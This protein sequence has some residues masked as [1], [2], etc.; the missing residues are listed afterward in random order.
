MKVCTKCCIQKEIEEF[1]KV[2]GKPRSRC[3]LCMREETKNYYTTHRAARRAKNAEWFAKNKQAVIYRRRLKKYNISVE[4][5]EQ[6]WIECGGKCLICKTPFDEQNRKNCLCVDHD[7]ACCPEQCHSCGKCVRGF[8][9]YSCNV[10]L[11]MFHDSAELMTVASEYI[12][13]RKLLRNIH[14]TS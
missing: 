12:N 10:G 1:H 11:A 6:F 9:C 8:V 7:N 2:R 13:D 4:Q 3:K 5:F 14:V